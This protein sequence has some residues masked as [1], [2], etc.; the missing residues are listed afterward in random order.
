MNVTGWNDLIDG[1]I[2]D[3]TTILYTSYYGHW[4]ITLLFLA[5][6]VMLYL[7]TRSVLLSFLTTSIFLSV[8]VTSASIE[9]TIILTISAI[10]TFELGALL[11]SIIFKK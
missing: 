6:K 10:G 2:F 1:R 9:P 8:A 4:Y 3:A 11:Y 5:F 7:G